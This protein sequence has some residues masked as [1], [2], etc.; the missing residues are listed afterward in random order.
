MPSR[1]E[2]IEQ[3]LLDGVSV[4]PLCSRPEIGH[5]P[6]EPARPGVA[7]AQSPVIGD[8]LASR[9]LSQ[10]LISDRSCGGNPA[11]DGS[12]PLLAARVLESDL[13]DPRAA[14]VDVALDPLSARHLLFVAHCFA[15]AVP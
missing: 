6:C 12:P 3:V 4:A 2:A 7:E 1:A 9:A 5:R 15:Y 11:L 14:A 10:E 8:S 13:V